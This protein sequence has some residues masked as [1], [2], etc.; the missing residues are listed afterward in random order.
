[1]FLIVLNT[2]QLYQL[3]TCGNGIVEDGE[4]CDTEGE[5]TAC[6]DPNTCK[7]KNNAVCEYVFPFSII[8]KQ[9]IDLIEYTNDS[10]D[11]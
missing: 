6:C 10:L 11:I 4:E 8:F 7:F 1:M 9:I 3:N 5:D 2:R